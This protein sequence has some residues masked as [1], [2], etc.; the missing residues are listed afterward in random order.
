MP[1]RWSVRSEGESERLEDRAVAQVR[2]LIRDGSLGPGEQ[3]PSEPELARR[4]GIS[5]PTL[6]AALSE[7]VA[8]RLLVRRKGV[9]TFVAANPPHVSQGLERLI[10]TGASIRDLGR[11][12]GT[13]GLELARQEASEDIADDLQVEAGAPVVHIR[14]TRT[15]DDRPVVHCEEWV[16]IDLLPTPTALDNLGPEDSLY[17]ALQDNGLHVRQAVTRFVPVLPD[18]DVRRRLAVRPREPVLLLEQRHYVGTEIDRVV[19]LSKN[20]YN[21][22]LIDLHLI[23]RD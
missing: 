10:G 9:G 4:L 23:R 8:D 14:R 11:T 7:L 2:A 19:L 12:P 21:T 22:A 6:R 17:Q 3:L 16:P 20:Y 18:D 5:R 15:A 13:V 1:S